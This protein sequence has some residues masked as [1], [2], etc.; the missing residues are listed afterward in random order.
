[1]ASGPGRSQECRT[2]VKERSRLR[3]RNNLLYRVRCVGDGD[4]PKMQHQLVIPTSARKCIPKH[5]HDKRGHMG[6][7]RTMALLRPGVSGQG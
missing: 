6:Q 5:V 2:L 4:S 7:D 1:M 3:M